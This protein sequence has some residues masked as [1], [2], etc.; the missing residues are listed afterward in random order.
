MVAL[1]KSVC[2]E[3]EK[4]IRQSIWGSIDGVRKIALVPWITLQMP[5]KEGGLRLHNL[6]DVNRASFMKIRWVILTK[7]S[8]LWVKIL[9]SKY[10]LSFDGIPQVRCSSICSSLW[11]NVYAVGRMCVWMSSGH[12]AMGCRFVDSKTSFP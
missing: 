1:P 4:M 12:W 8:A 3:I 11:R 6:K 2:N 10:K 7:T 9:R 5:R